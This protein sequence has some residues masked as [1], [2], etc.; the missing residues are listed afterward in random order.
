MESFPLRCRGQWAVNWHLKSTVHLPLLHVF[1]T[2]LALWA[3]KMRHEHNTRR[4]SA[5]YMHD[6]RDRRVNALRVRDN[7]AIHWDIEVDTTEGKYNETPTQYTP[8][9]Q[10]VCGCVC[11]CMCVCMCMCVCVCVREREREERERPFG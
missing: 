7:L 8:N 4:F 11:V 3:T 1:G 2:D 6:C 5:Q 10:S 9:A